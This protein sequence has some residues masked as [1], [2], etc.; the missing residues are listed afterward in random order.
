MAKLA[1]P[2]KKWFPLNV[3]GMFSWHCGGLTRCRAHV[4][5]WKRAAFIAPRAFSPTLEGFPERA[6]RFDCP[7]PSQNECPEN[8][9]QGW[10]ACVSQ[11]CG[12]LCLPS[13]TAFFGA[14]SSVLAGKDTSP[15]VLPGSGRN[16]RDVF[17][18]SL[19]PNYSRIVFI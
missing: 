11:L 13:E 2:E 15:K 6:A 1:L 12:E 3:N 16:P 5:A 14:A 10:R 4:L 17:T 8:E 19:Q 18:A 7:F 9:E